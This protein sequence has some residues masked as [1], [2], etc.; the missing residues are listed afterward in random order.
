[1][2]KIGRYVVATKLK[3]FLLFQKTIAEHTIDLCRILNK[4]FKVRSVNS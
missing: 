2:S 3:H 1:M 4:P